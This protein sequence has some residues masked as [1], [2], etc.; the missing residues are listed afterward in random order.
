[1]PTSFPMRL[2]EQWLAQ[3]R[4]RF[5]HPPT[6]LVR[7][8]K[9]RSFRFAGVA[10]S[11]WGQV[12]DW[13]SIVVG[14]DQHGYTWDLLADLDIAP[15]RLTTGG[16]RCRLCEPATRVI[17]LTRESLWIGHGFEALL[18]WSNAQFQADR[19]IS[20]WQLGEGCRWADLRPLAEMAIPT[21]E[22]VE[23]RKYKATLLHQLTIHRDEP[24]PAPELVAEYP[25]CW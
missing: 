24:V 25:L 7:R 8:K 9:S 18:A 2:F 1:M 6:A 23:R 13:G 21:A 11:V 20:L 5:R 15:E 14:V 16:Y 19:M 10:P 12:C 4:A 17:Y 3:N 22:K